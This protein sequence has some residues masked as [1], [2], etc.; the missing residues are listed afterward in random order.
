MARVQIDEIDEVD[1]VKSFRVL[2]SPDQATFDFAFLF[3]AVPTTPISTNGRSRR[4]D[5]LAVAPQPRTRSRTWQ[6]EARRISE[7][8]PTA[9]TSAARRD[10]H[11][12]GAQASARPVLGF[13]APPA[14]WPWPW[15]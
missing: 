14:S 12:Q 1:E 5:S 10:E 11:Y 7:Q 2:R 8:R 9:A 4:C 13:A 6:R 15:P 3:P